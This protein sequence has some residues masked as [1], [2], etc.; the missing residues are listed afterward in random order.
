MAGGP[1]IPASRGSHPIA[2]FGLNA[3]DRTACAPQN[4]WMSGWRHR[5]HDSNQ[6][7]EGTI[8]TH[9]PSPR[10]LGRPASLDERLVTNQ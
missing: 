3:L 1:L 4:T 5:A 6:R 7:L 8:P 10:G 9:A 2:G